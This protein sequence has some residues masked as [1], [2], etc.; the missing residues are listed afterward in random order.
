VPASLEPS[1]DNPIAIAGLVIA[2]L[3]LV[4]AVVLIGFFVALLSLVLSVVGLRRA[5]RGLV[6][7]KVSIAGIVLSVLAI[8]VSVV[9]LLFIVSFVQSFGEDTIRDGIA[10]TSTND[11]FPPQDDIDGVVCLSSTSGLVARAEVALTNR[12]VS[13]SIY[14]I[15]VEWVA[16]SGAIEESTISDYVAADES[17]TVTLLD[18][19]ETADPDACRVTRIERSLLPFF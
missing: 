8:V 13:P 16:D 15:T 14:E 19:S 10:T 18:L 4:L 11:E 1:R 6:G 3:A 7:R 17:I 9:S 2:V 5:G 12:S